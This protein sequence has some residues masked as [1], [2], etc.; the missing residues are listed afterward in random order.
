VA[1][2]IDRLELTGK[3]AALERNGKLV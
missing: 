3:R 1:Q 2:L